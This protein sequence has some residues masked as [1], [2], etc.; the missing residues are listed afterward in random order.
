M[1]LEYSVWESVGLNPLKPG[2]G[3]GGYRVGFSVQLGASPL[4]RRLH[5]GV[6]TFYDGG[7]PV[8]HKYFASGLFPGAKGLFQLTSGVTIT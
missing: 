6:H 5:R 8:S 3:E 1:S 4:K 7:F 2:G